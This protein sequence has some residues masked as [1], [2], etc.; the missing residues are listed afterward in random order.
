MNYREAIQ[1]QIAALQNIYDNCEGLRDAASEDEKTAWNTTRFML[2]KT[3]PVLQ[4]LD[5][6]MTD[7][8]AQLQLKGIYNV[9]QNT[10]TI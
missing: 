2:Q 4:K 10:K 6:T 3:W 9:I 8:R 1:I 5:N 7:N